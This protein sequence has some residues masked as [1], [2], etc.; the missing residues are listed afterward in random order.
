MQGRDHSLV[1]RIILPYFSQFVK[2]NQNEEK[3]DLKILEI[4]Q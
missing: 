2:I 1:L 4:L 3:N